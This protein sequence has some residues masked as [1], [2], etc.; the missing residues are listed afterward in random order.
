MN[1]RGV[2]QPG[3]PAA[4]GALLDVNALDQAVGV[5]GAAFGI[6]HPDVGVQQI[7]QDLLDVPRIPP[8]VAAGVA[9]T[10]FIQGELYQPR[11]VVLVG[12]AKTQQRED[13]AGVPHIQGRRK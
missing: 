13:G 2:G 11:A 3:V 8:A 9:T 1:R 6:R 4:D 10:E 12:P 5:R 7:A